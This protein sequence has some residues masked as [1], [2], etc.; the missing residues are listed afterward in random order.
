[1]DK[2]ISLKGAKI[3]LQGEQLTGAIT[4]ET[5]TDNGQRMLYAQ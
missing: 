4:V 1:M 2:N 3:S 5:K